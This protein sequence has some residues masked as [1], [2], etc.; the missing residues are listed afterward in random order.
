MYQA[1]REQL[2]PEIIEILD[3]VMAEE[4]LDDIW[5]PLERM[6]IWDLAEEFVESGNTVALIQVSEKSGIYEF[7]RGEKS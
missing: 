4:D 1:V 2:D 5:D 6:I 3:A 7:L